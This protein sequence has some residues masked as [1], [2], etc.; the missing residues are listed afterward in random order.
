MPEH[1]AV[2][3]V[4]GVGSP[5][6][7]ATA[8]S[9]AELL[10]RCAPNASDYR[11]FSEQHVI[12]PTD[13]VGAGPAR[14]GT[15]PSFWARIRN[16]FRF[17]DRV[18]LDTE[19][20]PFRPDVQFM[21]RQLAGYRSDRQPYAT[22]E[23]TGT[24]RRKEKETREITETTVHIYEMHWGDL[25]RVGAGFLRMLGALYQ[26]LQHVCHLG[27]KTLDIA[28]E[29]ARADDQ[30]SRHARAAGRYRRVHAMAVRL[31]TIAVPVATVLM[32]DWLFLFVPAAL[33]PSLRFPIAV[34]IAA[35]GLVVIAMMVAGFAAR[36]RHAARVVITVA[37]LA[38]G[39]AV[40][41]IVYAPKART[42]GIGSV[43]I[44]VLAVVL[45]I[46]TFAWFLARYHSTRPGA[47]GWG[48]GIV[49][50]VIVPVW[51]SRSLVAA[52]TLV[53]RLRN[54][55][56]VG[57]QWS[58]VALML[59]WIA[60]WL[61]MFVASGL[62][63]LV[64]RAAR[65]QP[66]K[67]RAGR[68]S[69][70]ARVT[71]AVT[72]FFFIM[73]ALVLYESLLN[74]AT[75]YHERL[76][77]FPH[78]TASAPL[79][80]VSRFLAP[81]LPRDEVDPPGQPGEQTHRF[82]EK[83]I[84]QSGTSGLRLAL[85]I[86][87]L[88]GILASWLVVIV[89]S[90]SIWTPP[91]DSP[92]WSRLGDWMTDGFA[93][94]RAAGLV[95]VTAVLAFIL[96]GLLAD[97]LRDVGA[98]P[99][100][101]WL[102][103][104]LDPNGMTPI[105]TRIA[106]VFGASAATIAALWLRVKTLANRARPALGILLDVDNYLRESPVDGTPR[107][108]MAERYASLLR[109]IVARKAP[110]T[111]TEQERPYFDR[112]V[113]VAHSQGTVISADFLRFLV[114]TQDPSVPLDGMDVRLLTMGSPLRQLYAKNFPHLYRWVDA[115]DDDAKPVDFEDRT[116]DPRALA[117]SK[118]VNL[119]TTGDYVGRTLWQPE[120]W[121][122]VWSTGFCRAGDRRTERCLGAGTHTRYWTSKD[123]ATEIDTLIG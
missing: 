13:P 59:S 1:V 55:G 122:D 17:E 29:E 14:D 61:A 86:V 83:L 31:F 115:S 100:W 110:A 51:A 3:A 87:L 93:L 25:S 112:I 113:I 50:A 12:L 75:R 91:A 78:A 35:I 65:T 18:E 74:V 92:R 107:A 73:T 114:A 49:L 97:T 39:G 4:H 71:I 30:G 48:W 27:R 33:R 116:P 62:R 123:V 69:W 121:D 101:P 32:L 40:G 63:L 52:P 38:V 80:I 41:A 99:S 72:V 26:L 20:K 76:D 37:L 119:Y 79:P 60:L 23:L 11:A 9:I 106:I 68:A 5:P 103:R 96:I 95:L 58:Y 118:W 34:A 108:R 81:D 15:R 42:E 57:F 111:A 54:V 84:A 66:E 102:R 45:A 98:L 43:A 89:I 88:A 67:A 70:T 94:L 104:L 56:F 22:I 47:L 44:A 36:M 77:I 120:D 46:A 117:V 105:L 90:T 109:Y 28:F 64:Y 53:E 19:L 24:R 85:V 2:I 21:R 10:V 8:R 82:L 16:A 7:D 6:Q